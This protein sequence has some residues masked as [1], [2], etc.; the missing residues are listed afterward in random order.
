MKNT[1]FCPLLH[2]HLEGLPP[3]FFQLGGLDPI[4]DEGILYDKVL[5]DSNVR[6]KLMVYDGFGHMFWTNC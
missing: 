4:R 6:T 1:L 2:P 3:A 5:K